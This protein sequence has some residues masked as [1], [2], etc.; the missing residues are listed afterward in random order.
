MIVMKFGG[1]SVED[2][3]AIERAAAIVKGRRAQK[4]VVVV[5]A[6]AKVTDQLLAMA[7]A[8]GA[9]DRKTALKL[10]R[11]LQER[12]YNTAGELLGTALFTQFHSDL[13]VDFEALDELLRGIAAVG[14][15][16]ARTTDHVAAFGEMLS[17]KIVTAAFSAHG[18]ES[19]L[20]DSRDCIVTD[21]SHTRAAPLF[22]E[23]NERL[24]TN[25]QP[26]L[27]KDR[28]PVMGGFIG[29]TKAGITTTIGRGGSDLS[30]A[31]VGAGLGAE[32]IEIW[33][34]V[35]G[36]MTTDPHL[37]PEARRI[38]VISFDEAAE[39]AYFGA[40]VLHP[41]TVLPA[42][43]K[44][45]PVYVLN[46][47]NP[48]CEGTRITARAPTCRNT[49]KALAV[50]KRIT[51]VDVAA[52]RRLLM[53]GFLKSIFEAFDR[54][55]VPVDVVSTSEVSVSLTTDSN[56]SIPALAADLAKLAD[57]KYEG[58][59]AIVCLVGENLR[60]TPGIAARVFGEL[61]DVKIRMISQGASEIN[62][63]FV[64]EEDAVP[65]V[66]RRLHK[67]FFS[68]LDADVFA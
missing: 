40:K 42:V 61:A 3:K 56:E 48:S 33:T 58:R 30:A 64:I 62:L 18:I 15:L 34:D 26:L 43:Q 31:I 32:R 38:K 7:R 27:D 2:A 24:R 54:H 59:K 28:V 36:M 10:C 25:L 23:T 39:L 5:S 57:V 41:A 1:T 16:T 17:S 68:D 14:E 6:M 60:E 13:G 66:V 53:H 29:S 19:A 22:E 21:N 51:I 46:S 11:A 55:R 52:P 47:R 20:V 50:K 65:E 37:C 45:I 8:A 9:G 63:T 67:T 49:F 44:N 35:D 4:P 12:H